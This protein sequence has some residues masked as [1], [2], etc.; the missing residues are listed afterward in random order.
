MGQ[1]VHPLR[2]LYLAVGIPTDSGRE[3]RDRGSV[4][5]EISRTRRLNLTHGQLKKLKIYRF[6]VLKILRKS[7]IIEG[8]VPITKSQG[9]RWSK[10]RWRADHGE[11]IWDR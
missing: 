7:A 9:Q 6:K 3:L 4:Q 8:L 1:L 5:T 11:S 10:E 2:I